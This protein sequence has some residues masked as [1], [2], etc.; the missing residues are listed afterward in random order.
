MYKTH[1]IVAL[2]NICKTFGYA[3]RTNVLKGISF[4]V[5]EGELLVI[6]GASG[7][8]KSTLL[9][10]IGGIDKPSSGQVIVE[11][12]DIACFNNK[13]LTIYRRDKVGFVFQ[14][15][16]LISDLT[17]YENISLV[18]SI[19]RDPISVED[20]LNAVGLLHRRDYYPS[21]ISGGEQQRV[22]IARALIKKPKILICDEPTGAL[23]S[24]T[25]KQILK[26][27]EKLTKEQRQT[28]IMATHNQNLATIA[29]RVI[30]MS[31]GEIKAIENN[32][33]PLNVK[34]VN[35]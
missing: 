6:L 3:Y 15:Y 12:K 34:E 25:E 27:L 32:V 13:K 24:K 23:D 28:T 17:V 22:A 5:Y 35:W 8:G 18:S 10:I 26:Y 11:E 30:K 31:N 16:N 14:F 1:K 9:N 29:N 2:K 19:S 33:S 20:A 21:Q 7:C 4:D